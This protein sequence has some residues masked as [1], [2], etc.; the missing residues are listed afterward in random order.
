[1]ER[2]DQHWQKPVAPED[3]INAGKG[4]EANGSGRLVG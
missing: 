4:D 1:L 2:F 3:G